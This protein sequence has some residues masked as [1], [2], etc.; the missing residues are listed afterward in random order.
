MICD[1][2][3]HMTE[4]QDRNPYNVY[5]GFVAGRLQACKMKSS[6]FS[7]AVYWCTVSAPLNL[8]L[9]NIHLPAYTATV[10]GPPKQRNSLSACH[11][12]KLLTLSPKTTDYLTVRN[13]LNVVQNSNCNTDWKADLLPFQAW[14]I[15]GVSLNQ[16]AP[17]AQCECFVKGRGF[18]GD[19]TDTEFS[20]LW[21]F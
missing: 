7:E 11:N 1:L 5:P 3:V 6:W 8:Q 10:K 17:Y 16:S 14:L 15:L 4:L 13:D 20:L 18:R 21:T 9:Y 12:F 19:G 2:K